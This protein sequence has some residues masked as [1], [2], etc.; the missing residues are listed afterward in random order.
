[1]L[2]VILGLAVLVFIAGWVFGGVLL[3][4]LGLA[5]LV[6]GAVSLIVTQDAAAALVLAIGVVMW[7]AGH[8]HDA[9]RHHEYAS[10]LAQRLFQRSLP[11]KFDPTREWSL[12]VHSGHESDRVRRPTRR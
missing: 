12:P 1:M 3:H 9:L 5:L 8:W 2:A 11:S 6:L 4:A 7:L 10:P